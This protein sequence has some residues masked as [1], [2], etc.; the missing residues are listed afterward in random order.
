MTVRVRKHLDSD[1]IHLPEAA[2]LIGRDVEIVITE[3]PVNNRPSATE[4]LLGL[5]GRDVLD[6]EAY[7]ELRARSVL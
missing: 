6:P 7:K 5:A 1:T 2:P 4:V 3:Q